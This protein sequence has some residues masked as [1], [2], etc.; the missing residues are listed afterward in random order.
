VTAAR[1]SRRLPL[2]LPADAGAHLRGPSLPRL[3]WLAPLLAALALA[4][5]LALGSTPAQAAFQVGLQDVAFDGDASPQQTAEGYNVLGAVHGSLV[6][7]NAFWYAIAPADPGPRAAD[8]SNPQYHWG[9]LDTAVRNAAARRVTPVLTLSGVPTWAQGA[10]RPAN[11]AFGFGVWDPNAADYAQFIRAAA[12][13]Y[14]GHFADPQNP[15]RL[16][17][18][19]RYFEIWNEENIPLF[20]A[21][22]DLAASY[23]ALLSGAYA[24]IKSVDP[25]DKVVLGGLAPLGYAG[26][27]G[28]LKLG[29]Q[30]LC[31]RRVG[32]RFVRVSGCSAAPF[33][34]FAQHP[35]SLGVT[36]T[37]KVPAQVYD[38]V[39]V[40]DF[41]KVRNLLNAAARLH[42]LG[43]RRPALW[44]TE[45]GWATNPP[46]RKVGDH[47]NAAA[48]YVAYSMYEMYKQGA[49]LVVWQEIHD[50]TANGLPGSGLETNSGRRKPSMQAFTF[51]FIAS[52]SHR[53]GFGWGR[54]PVSHRVRIFVQRRTRRGWR[55]VASARTG[56]DG[57]FS[58]HFAASGNATYRAQVS[59]GPR[60]LAYNSAPIPPRPTH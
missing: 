27:P 41:Y 12:L 17:P 25:S 45:W 20:M 52:V 44:V 50:G 1:H 5:V 46:D 59:H 30:L 49:S 51:P 11:P 4:L 21:A 33:D 32:T 19:V 47:F 55:T 58:A 43:N 26:S 37:E 56:S 53:R 35:Y 22:P 38:D 34:I 36:P 28:P 48:R 29:A 40:G 2:P 23:R 14:D 6:R 16:L 24:S 3:R 60:S 13:R 10:N 57:I 31:L 15:G 8:P 9:A 7:L 39:R 54:A 18:R 42:T